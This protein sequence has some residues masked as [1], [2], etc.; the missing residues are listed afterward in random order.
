MSVNLPLPMLRALTL[1]G[2][3]H[4]QP[5]LTERQRQRIASFAKRR[6]LPAKAIVYK[7]GRTIYVNRTANPETL[8]WDDVLVIQRFTGSQLCKLDRVTTVDRTGGFFSGV[9]FLSDFV[10]YTLPENDG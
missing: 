6:Q 8:D 2:I 4:P 1:N 7:D 3:G 9:V 10:P 5:L